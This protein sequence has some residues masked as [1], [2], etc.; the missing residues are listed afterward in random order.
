MQIY[1]AR[2]PG[3][4]QNATMGNAPKST[5]TPWPSLCS[6][7]TVLERSPSK[8]R[9]STGQTPH[10]AK[11]WYLFPAGNAPAILTQASRPPPQQCPRIL[12][13]FKHQPVILKLLPGADGAAESRMP[14]DA[15]EHG[16]SARILH[17]KAR[18]ESIFGQSMAH[19]KHKRVWILCQS[20]GILPQTKLHEIRSL[21]RHGDIRRRVKA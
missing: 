1:G 19:G 6:S 2:T 14:A 21:R 7:R 4:V 5:S 8:T 16:F 20:V 18:F 12:L 10:G 15:K 3:M 13:P 9:V 11:G 17:A